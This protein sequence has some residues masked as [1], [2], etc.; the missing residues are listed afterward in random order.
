MCD[1][2]H[3]K[4]YTHWYPFKLLQENTLFKLSLLDKTYMN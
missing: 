1:S 4:I 3:F 2:I